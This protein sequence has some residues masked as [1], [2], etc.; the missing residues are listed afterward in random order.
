[1]E[2]QHVKENLVQRPLGVVALVPTLRNPIVDQFYAPFDD[3]ESQ[4]KSEIIYS[5]Q[6]NRLVD[7]K[8]VIIH[9][10]VGQGR[11]KNKTGKSFPSLPASHIQF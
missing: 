1:V 8:E 2:P 9:F 10:A 7:L 11:F 3:L 5:K 4:I 6:L